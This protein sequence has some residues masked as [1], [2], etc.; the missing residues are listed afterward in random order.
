MLQTATIAP[1]TLELLNHLQAEPTL[2][3]TRLVGGR[4]AGLE[5]CCYQ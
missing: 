5:D 2:R 3:S 1:G 4:T